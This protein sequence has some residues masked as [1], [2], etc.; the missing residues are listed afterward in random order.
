MEIRIGRTTLRATAKYPHSCGLEIVGNLGLSKINRD[1]RRQL[2]I[3]FCEVGRGR[4]RVELY[5]TNR[6][7]RDRI[8]TVGERGVW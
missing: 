1:D 3:A 8:V 7:F 5:R 6:Y 4:F 2:G